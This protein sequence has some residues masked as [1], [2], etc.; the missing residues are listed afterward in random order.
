M[1][2][3]IGLGVGR[4]PCPSRYALGPMVSS[5]SV[6]KKSRL[7]FKMFPY[8]F[9]SKFISGNYLPSNILWRSGNGYQI[10]FVVVELKERTF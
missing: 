9:S 5:Y 8:F 4:V 2:E 6:S 1:Q 10:K 7:F 3:N